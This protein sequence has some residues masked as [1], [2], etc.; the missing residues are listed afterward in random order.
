MDYILALPKLQ[1]LH[2]YALLDLEL[3]DK[4]ISGGFTKDRQF[5]LN[6]MKVRYGLYVFN[7]SPDRFTEK[8]EWMKDECRKG[9]RTVGRQNVSKMMILINHFNKSI[10]LSLFGAVL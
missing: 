1:R 8:R 2:C 9:G 5:Y 10:G 3:G 6:Q 4:T 7:Q